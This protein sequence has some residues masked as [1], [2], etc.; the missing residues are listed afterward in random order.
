MN[1]TITYK[2]NLIPF[3][4]KTLQAPPTEIVFNITLGTES[5]IDNP[6]TEQL[7]RDSVTPYLNSVKEEIAGIMKATDD[8][9]QMDDI[10]E[11]TAEVLVEQLNRNF[12]HII[13]DA[14][15]MGQKLVMKQW[16]ELVKENDSL[17]VWKIKTKVEIGKAGFGSLVGAVNVFTTGGWGVIWEIIPLVNDIL[18]VYSNVKKLAIGEEKARKE[19]LEVMDYITKKLAGEERGFFDKLSDFFSGK[20]NDL[21]EEIE[22]YIQKLT[23]VRHEIE[24]LAM[25]VYELLDKQDNLQTSLR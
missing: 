3:K 18:T 25:K 7:L 1:H 20:E 12:G 8:T 9:L 6:F 16:K 24:K 21:E 5:K 10:D 4:T 11:E 22:T 19:L 14:E 15:K 17:K 2:A 23:G 13:E